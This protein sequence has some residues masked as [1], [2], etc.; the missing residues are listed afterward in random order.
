MTTG[1]PGGPGGCALPLRVNLWLGGEG[2]DSPAALMALTLNSY[3]ESV[4]NPVQV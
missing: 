1:V 4:T 3:S 2:R